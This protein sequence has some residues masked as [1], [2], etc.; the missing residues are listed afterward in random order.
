[1]E[2]MTPLH[3]ASVEGN[4]E[5]VRLL[6]DHG[7]NA[8]AEDKRGRTTFQVAFGEWKGRDCTIVDR[9]WRTTT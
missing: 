8:D 1:M 9:T 7:A 5:V 3:L 4:S 2:D 6:L